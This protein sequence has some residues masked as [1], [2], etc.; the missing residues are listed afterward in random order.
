MSEEKIIP[1]KRVKSVAQAVE[2]YSGDSSGSDT[3]RPQRKS[4]LTSLL[5]IALV[6]VGGFATYTGYQLY[7]MKKNQDPAYQQELA[8]KKT[9]EV[10]TAV[11]KIMELPEGEPQVAQVADVEAIK[12]TQPFFAK[13]QN[14]DMVLVYA[15]QA[16]IYR[17]STNKIINVGP[18]TRDSTKDA[19][20][21]QS[22][23]QA[24][25]PQASESTK[26]SKPIVS[27]TPTDKTKK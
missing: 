7:K 24:Q 10:T 17:P 27:E 25:A 4:K 8:K 23:A 26:P 5:L 9:Q 19:P 2:E 13:A 20:K 15:S 16:I 22:P 12:K 18:V 1:T 14:G 11:Q 21:V 6:L 3:Q